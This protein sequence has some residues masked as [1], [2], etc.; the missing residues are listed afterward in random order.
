MESE[1]ADHAKIIYFSEARPFQRSMVSR[2]PYFMVQWDYKGQRGYGHVIESRDDEHGIKKAGTDNEEP[3]YADG[4]HVGGAGF[5]KY[6]PL[7]TNT[8][9]LRKRF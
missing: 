3:T 5:P 8:G 1:W 7:C 2:L 4:D 6:V 9:T